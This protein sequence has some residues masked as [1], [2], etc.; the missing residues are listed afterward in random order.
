[1]LRSDP[2]LNL[3]PARDFPI[4]ESKCDCSRVSELRTPHR[5]NTP[6]NRQTG[7]GAQDFRSKVREGIVG[8]R[9]ELEPWI[10]FL[11][12]AQ[13]ERARLSEPR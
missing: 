3:V 8:Q 13:K 1:M 12:G 5:T 6:A 9:S 11:A 2:E 4:P 10:L 7:E